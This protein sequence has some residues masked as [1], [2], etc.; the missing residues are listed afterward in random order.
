VN[1]NDGS[2]LGQPA[3]GVA[4]GDKWRLFLYKVGGD[5]IPDDSR[6]RVNPKDRHPV[7]LWN[8]NPP[9]IRIRHVGYGFRT[10]EP[11]FET[12]RETS[13]GKG[14]GSRVDDED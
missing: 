14:Y 4:Q 2:G 8:P 10:W 5:V 6:N 9:N 11:V 7:S 12:G 3:I 1:D 13:Y